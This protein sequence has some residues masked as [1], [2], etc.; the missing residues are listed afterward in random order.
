MTVSKVCASAGDVEGFACSQCA[1]QSPGEA[2]DFAFCLLAAHSSSF[3]KGGDPFLRSQGR[4][5][6]IMSGALAYCW[7]APFVRET[8]LALCKLI[9]GAARLQHAVNIGLNKSQKVEKLFAS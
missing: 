4:S 7:A 3:G 1:S 9:L 5:C 2:W 8:V 6:C